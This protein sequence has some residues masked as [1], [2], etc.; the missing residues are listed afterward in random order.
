[1]NG[2]L[3]C[4]ATRRAQVEGASNMALACTAAGHSPARRR[5]TAAKQAYITVFGGDIGVVYS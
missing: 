2:F 1:M 5:S 4:N 3:G